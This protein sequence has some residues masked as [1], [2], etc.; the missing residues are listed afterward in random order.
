M[1]VQVYGVLNNA[2]SHSDNIPKQSKGFFIIILCELN[3]DFAQKDDQAFNSSI[4]IFID[5]NKE[6]EDELFW[7]RERE[8]LKK[9]KQFYF[10]KS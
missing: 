4:Q 2:K 3:H 1:S 10:V 8:N 5:N 6:V 7:V 9:K